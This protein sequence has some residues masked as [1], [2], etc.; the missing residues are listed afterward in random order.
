MKVDGWRSDRVRERE[1]GLIVSDYCRYC[2]VETRRG[3][4]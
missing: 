3:R 2:E 1:E 4:G